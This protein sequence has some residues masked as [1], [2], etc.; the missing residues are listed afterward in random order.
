[1]C[2]Y[3][4]IDRHGRRASRDDG[5]DSLLQRDS[6]PRLMKGR[7][8]SSRA[9]HRLKWMLMLLP[10]SHLAFGAGAKSMVDQ[11]CAKGLPDTPQSNCCTSAPAVRSNFPAC[12][13]TDPLTTL[14]HSRHPASQHFLKIAAF[15]LAM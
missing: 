11:D 10:A 8:S 15:Y 12:G 6:A 14:F 2:F 9:D 1:M 13:Y 7:P 3:T 4:C 5:K